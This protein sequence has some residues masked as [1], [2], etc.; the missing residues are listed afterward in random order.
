MLIEKIIAFILSSVLTSELIKGSEKQFIDFLEHVAVVQN[1]P[2]LKVLVDAL[3][4]ALN[5]PVESK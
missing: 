3:A 4:R 2:A 1:H 5:V